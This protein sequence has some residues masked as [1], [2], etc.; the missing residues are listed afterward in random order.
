MI[1]ENSEGI[2]DYFKMKFKNIDVC[3]KGINFKQILE[4]EEKLKIKDLK[5]LN[6]IYK[7]HIHKHV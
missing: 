5:E 6:E 7:K 3:E 2:L 1:Q 4:N